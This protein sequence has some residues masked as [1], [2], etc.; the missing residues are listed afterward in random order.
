[1]ACSEAV[2]TQLRRVADDV[3]C[4][5]IDDCGHFV[6][7]EMPEALLAILTPFLEPYRQAARE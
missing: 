4:T 2:E 6:P 7:E 5:I 3:R 1:L